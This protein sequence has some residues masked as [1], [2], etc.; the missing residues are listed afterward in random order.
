MQLS[1]PPNR[2]DLRAEANFPSKVNASVVRWCPWCDSLTAFGVRGW[3]VMKPTEIC[4]DKRD[5]RNSRPDWEATFLCYSW[6]WSVRWCLCWACLCLCGVQILVPPQE[7]H[8]GTM[9]EASD[10]SM[11]RRHVTKIWVTPYKRGPTRRTWSAAPIK[12]NIIWTNN[13]D[14]SFEVRQRI[15]HRSLLTLFK[16]CMTSS[17]PREG[18]NDAIS[19]DN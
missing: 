17:R 9:Q 14:G 10:I 18:N 8:T 13:R 3:L 19:D 5:T 1:K 7:L 16:R 4:V 15:I 2:W 12:K 11:L 6:L